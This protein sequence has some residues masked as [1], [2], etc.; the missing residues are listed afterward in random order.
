MEVLWSDDLVVGVR[1]LDKQHEHLIK[2]LN[3]FLLVT[4]AREFNEDYQD[5]V[6]RLITC[7]QDHFRDEEELMRKHQYPNIIEHETDHSQFMVLINMMSTYHYDEV[8]TPDA[9]SR[10]VKR[11]ISD[12]IM[13]KD[14]DL[15]MYLNGRGVN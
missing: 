11:W 15:G 4:H 12:H 7:Y 14:K 6:C 2:L 13:E 3:D 10:F 9:V 8:N 1:S 5:I